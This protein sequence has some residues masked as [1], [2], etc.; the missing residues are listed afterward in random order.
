MIF[1]WLGLVLV[2]LI[3]LVVASRSAIDHAQALAFGTKIP[4]FLIGIT[5]MS[6][7]TDLPEIANSIVASVGGHGDINVGDSIGSAVTQMTLVLGLLPWLA[8]PIDVSRKRVLVV[9]G[10][11]V[12]A[13][14]GGAWFVSDGYLARVEAAALLSWWVF[15]SV[16]IWKGTGPI[17]EPALPVPARKPLLNTLSLFGALIAV[18]ISASALVFAFVRLSEAVGIPEY[19]LTFFVA[20]IGTSLPEL[21]VDVTALRRGLKDMA[22]G[23]ILGSSFVDA[24][25]SLGIGPLIAP[26]AVT[27]ALAVRGAWVGAAAVALVAFV[28]VTRRQHNRLSGLM[29]IAVYVG[30]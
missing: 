10:A 15:G 28:L 16:L 13:L 1:A 20:S 17:A 4:P 30:V 7:G 25:L 2:S 6:V 8:P 11:C 22:L 27:A 12:A 23:D 19:L 3:G 26:T 5:L 24:T 9:C 14:L 29:L 18:T 21:F